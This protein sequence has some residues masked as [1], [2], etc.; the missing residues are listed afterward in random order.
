MAIPLLIAV[1]IEPEHL[2]SLAAAGFDPVVVPGRA[3]RAAFIRAQ[4]AGIRGVLTNGSTGLDAAEMAALP[5]LEIVCAQGAGFEKVDVAAARARGIAVTHGPG[6][7]DASVSDHAM[8]LLLGIARGLVETDAGVRRG[9]WMASRRP[10]PTVSGRKLGILGLGTIGEQIARRGA[11]GFDMTVAY[12]NRRP[13]DG[14]PYLYLPSPTALAGWS[15]F[16]VVA[17]PGGAATQHLVDAAVLDAL[18]PEGFLVNIARGSVV[19]TAAL[20]RALE[21]GRIGGAALDVVEG[22]PQ[23]PQGLVGLANV[24]LTPHIAG[25]SPEAIKATVDLVIANLAAHFAGRA[26]LTPVPGS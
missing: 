13:R 9:E 18:G 24:L 1:D 2:E 19:D 17:T 14:A 5:R 7:N 10:R 16:L 4:G 25:R 26:V 23:V 3:E 6:T 8:A 15:D 12:H 11:G 22:E 20:I 21:A